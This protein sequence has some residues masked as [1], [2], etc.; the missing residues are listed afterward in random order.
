MRYRHKWDGDICIKCLRSK[1]FVLGGC[2]FR[3]EKKYN[4]RWDSKEGKLV[5]CIKCGEQRLLLRRF[6]CSSDRGLYPCPISG[7]EHDIKEIIE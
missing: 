1:G 2:R 3:S 6:F 4:H 7:K 5:V